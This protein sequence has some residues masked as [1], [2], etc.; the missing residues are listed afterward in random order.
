MG[1]GKTKSVN[2]RLTQL[3]NL[4]QGIIDHQEAIVEA[5]KDD[6]GRPAFESYFELATLG[7]INLALQKLKSCTKPQRVAT[8][9]DQ[10]PA[11]AWVQPEPLGVVLIIGPWNYPFQLM[12]SPLVEAIISWK[13]CYPQT[14]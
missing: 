12:I 2:F 5:T 14:F 13:L 1:T 3:E 7:E 10:F 6:L 4:K 11:L 9:V 8:S